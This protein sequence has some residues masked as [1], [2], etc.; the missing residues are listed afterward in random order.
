MSHHP[1]SAELAAF[2]LA[3]LPGAVHVAMKFGGFCH[4]DAG[5]WPEEVALGIGRSTGWGRTDADAVSSMG[6]RAIHEAS[7]MRTAAFATTSH[8]LPNVCEAP[9]HPLGVQTILDQTFR[10]GDRLYTAAWLDERERG[11]PAW[12]WPAKDDP[13]SDGF[14]CE[15]S[16]YQSRGR[17]V[18]DAVVGVGGFSA[19]DVQAY[20]YCEHHR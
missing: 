9:G 16:C 12:R 17:W 8:M 6:A 14:E 13:C 10:P 18:H 11:C 19:F 3:L 2:R 1:T 5:A 15:R 4:P 20:C 7:V